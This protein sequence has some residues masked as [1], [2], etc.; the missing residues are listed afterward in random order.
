MSVPHY[1]D[2]CSFVISF[3]VRKCEISYFVLLFKIAL[4]IQ[5]SLSFH[6]N[7]RIGFYISA[8]GILIGIAFN[9]WVPLGGIDILTILSSN[10]WTWEFF[11]F[12][13]VIFN[14]LQQCFTVFSVF[15]S[16]SPFWL[17]LFLIIS[18]FSMILWTELF[19]QFPFLIVHH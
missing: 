14:F 11:P 3:E 12:I 17:S 7:F 6:I 13:V 5:C 9:L 10:P 8:V 4:A 2:Y 15:F 1:I 19:S 18:F 16:L